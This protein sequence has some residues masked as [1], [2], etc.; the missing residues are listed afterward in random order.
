M[1][2]FFLCALPFVVRLLHNTI[3]MLNRY[4]TKLSMHGKDEEEE[5]QENEEKER[6]RREK[7]KDRE[8]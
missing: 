7:K 4:T 1:S 6:G 3:Y 8:P 2:F 5:E